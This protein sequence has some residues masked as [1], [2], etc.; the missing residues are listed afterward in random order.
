MELA[1]YEEIERLMAETGPGAPFKIVV[2]KKRTDGKRPDRCREFLVTE[3]ERLDVIPEMFG[4]GEFTLQLKDQVGRYLKQAQVS[5]SADL[6]PP[7]RPLARPAEPGA[8]L[9]PAAAAPDRFSELFLMMQQESR[10]QQDRY[11]SLLQSI[12]VAVIGK[13]AP[14]L[15]DRVDELNALRGLTAGS[16]APPAPA[17][18]LK[19]MLMAGVQIGGG[20]KPGD[21]GDEDA[22]GSGMARVIEKGLDLVTRAMDRVPGPRRAPVAGQA[23]AAAAVPEHLR[24]YTWLLKYVPQAI[25]FAKGGASPARAAAAIYALI[26]DEHLDVLESFSRMPVAERRQLLVQ[27]DERLTPYLAFLDELAAQLV[28]TFD[29]EAAEDVDDEQNAARPAESA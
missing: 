22:E 28:I 2:W 18:V 19:D 24:P 12:V 10:A 20:R 29:R 9:A 7:P 21:A 16:N 26:P 13:G 1:A 23:A 27:L 3:L 5:W 11:M 17:E 15:K 8:P 4:G 14:T 6:Y 25:G